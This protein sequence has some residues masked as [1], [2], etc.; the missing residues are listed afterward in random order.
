MNELTKMI[1]EMQAIEL[2]FL[3]ESSKLLVCVDDGAITE[4]DAWE[5]IALF[6]RSRVEGW[7]R[8]EAD[9]PQAFTARTPRTH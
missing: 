9:Y 2:E 6:S 4:E 1:H 3:A 8:L 7:N 5:Q